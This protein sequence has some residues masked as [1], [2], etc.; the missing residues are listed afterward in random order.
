MSHRV[1]CQPNDID[2]KNE[3]FCV[4]C[5]K[6]FCDPA[7]P[8]NSCEIGRKCSHAVAARNKGRHEIIIFR[9]RAF[10]ATCHKKYGNGRECSA[11]LA[12]L[13]AEERQVVYEHQPSIACAGQDTYKL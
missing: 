5:H 12:I 10:C 9:S 13:E 2:G 1:I 8:H 7:R 4:D 11:V 6:N 3:M